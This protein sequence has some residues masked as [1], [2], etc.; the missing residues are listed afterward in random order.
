MLPDSTISLYIDKAFD[1]DILTLKLAPW[2]GKKLIMKV[3]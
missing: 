1:F 2:R 3:L